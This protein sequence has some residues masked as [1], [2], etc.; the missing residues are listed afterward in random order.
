MASI[1]ASSN[2]PPPQAAQQSSEPKFVQ[3]LAY[4]LLVSMLIWAIIALAIYQLV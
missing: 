2:V 3:G 4:G 1:T